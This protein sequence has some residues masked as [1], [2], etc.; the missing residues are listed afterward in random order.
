MLLRRFSLL[1]M[2]LLCL[3]IGSA[4]PVADT[5]TAA[6]LAQ[7][8]QDHPRLPHPSRD[9]LLTLEK[10]GRPWLSTQRRRAGQGDWQA[11][12][13]LA[14]NKPD[15]VTLDSLLE[16]LLALQFTDRGHKQVK[17][18]AVAYD[19][20]YPHWSENQRR[21]LLG[22]L[23]DGCDY[24]RGFIREQQLSPYNVFLYNSPMQAWMACSIATRHDDPRGSEH[25]FEMSAYWKGIILPVWR[26]IFGR[27]G[28]W[29]EG[30]EYVGIGIGQAIYQL[31]A[32]WRAATGEDL[33]KSEPGLRGFLDFYLHRIRPDLTHIRWGDAGWFNRGAKDRLAL[34]ME[35]GHQAAFSL[36]QERWVKPTGWP[37]GPLTEPTWYDAEARSRL[38]LWAHFDGIGLIT[39]RTSWQEDA[40]FTS[41]KAGDN[42][43]SHSHL[44]QGAFTL[45]HGGA[46]AIDSGLYGPRYGSDHHMN[47]TYQSIAHNLI[48]VTDPA[49]TAPL[50]TG[51]R[52]A[53]DGGQRRI[54]SGWG[55]HPAPM[56][57][58]QWQE[59]SEL[60]HTARMISVENFDG[61]TI[62]VA[63]ITPAWTNADSG[64]GSGSQR[65][66][67]VER[68]LRVFAH[69]RIDDVVLV[70]DHIISSKAEFKKRW[71]LHSLQRAA[72]TPYGFELNVA[73]RPRIGRQGGY[74][75]AHVIEPQQNELTNIGG[76]GKQWWVDGKNWDA[77]GKI[78]AVVVRRKGLAEPGSWRVELSPKKEAVEDRFLVIMLPSDR[79]SLPTQ[80][81]QATKD[82]NGNG[83]EIQGDAHISRWQFDT[84]EG[85][86]RLQL[87][88]RKGR[89]QNYSLP[90]E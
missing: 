43:W 90:L 80:K 40:T 79:G 17:P 50:T 69:D 2:A 6:N 88:D 64:S 47:Y 49:D 31:P 10:H 71:L 56:N 45:Y 22:R 26:Q 11:R 14:Y 8:Q 7:L 18:L 19:W 4:S 37:W 9:E 3:G 55:E 75:Q 81:V 5:D 63:D 39:S 41:F 77:D 62:A 65:T 84:E 12:L 21:Q 52:Y 29:H 25:F 44:D 34:A 24:V 60:Y 66:R 30:G 82:P 13:F 1:A 32:M 28:G 74:L 27:N 36:H 61:I 73:P 20:L 58:Q 33:F 51:K 38:P 76:P 23:L 42:F 48:T 16:E 53:N 46:L 87:K 68:H 67:R 70:F 54:G 57:R 83:V 85:R 89:W 59:Q 86:L 35:T 15:R 78:P 72:K